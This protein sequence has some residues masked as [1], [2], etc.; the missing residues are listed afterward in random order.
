MQPC[1]SH[2]SRAWVTSLTSQ[3][4]WHGCLMIACRNSSFVVSS[5]TANDQLVGKRNVSRT[6]LRNPSQDLTSMSPTVKPVHRID[7]CGAVCFIPEQEELKK[8]AGLYSTTS[9]SAGPTYPCPECGSVLQ[10]R[11]GLISHLR[12]HHHH[13]HQH[14]RSYGHH[15][16][17]WTNMMYVCKYVCV[18]TFM[19]VCMPVCADWANVSVGA[20]RR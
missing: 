15:R 14:R 19:S 10:A 6:P 2:F 17:Q 4:T 8:T 9:T 20:N 1:V 13:H 7:P 5:A 16:K 12:T 18:F 3:A 11:N